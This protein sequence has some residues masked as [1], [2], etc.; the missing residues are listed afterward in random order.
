MKFNKTDDC[1]IAI[2]KLEQA[3]VRDKILEQTLHTPLI[4]CIIDFAWN[5]FIRSIA[6]IENKW[7]DTLFI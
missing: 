5:A 3:E 1:F 4:N 6:F 7:Q 2:L